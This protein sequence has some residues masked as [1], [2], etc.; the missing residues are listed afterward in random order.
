MGW[1]FEV[2]MVAWRWGAVALASLLSGA[3]A[4][5]VVQDDYDHGG[6]P[7]RQYFEASEPVQAVCML[8]VHVGRA[9]ARAPVCASY[10]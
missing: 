10:L 9:D 8:L 4:Y 1:G 2:P 7:H 5:R 6:E 3:M